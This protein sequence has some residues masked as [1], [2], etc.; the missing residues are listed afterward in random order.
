MYSEYQNNR[1]W[2]LKAT[3]KACERTILNLKR[4]KLLLKLNTSNV[5]FV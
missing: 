4:M 5:N 1:F 2:I 3:K